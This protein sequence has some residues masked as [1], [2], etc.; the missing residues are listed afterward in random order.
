[1]IE[2]SHLQKVVDGRTVLDIATLTVPAGQIAALVGPVG[3]GQEALLALLTGEARPSLGQVRIAGIDPHLERERFSHAVGV[4]FAEDGLYERQS[5][6]ENLVFHCQL[7]SLPRAR[8]ESVLAQVGLGDHAHLRVDKLASGMKRRLAFGRAILH[9]PAVLLLEEPFARCDQASI[10]LL[11]DLMRQQ[12]AAGCSLLILATDAANLAP[13]CNTIY[14]L[15]QGRVVESRQPQAEQTHADLPF[16]VPVRLE[17]KVAL[18]N[19]G[20]ILFAEVEDGRTFLQTREG[21]LPTQFTLS[22]LEERL[23]RSGFFRAHRAYLVNMQHIKE[24]IP[25]TRDSFSLRLDDPA[26]TEIPL[27]KSAANELKELLG[28]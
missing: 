28:Y 5:A 23:G 3:S 27:S 21:R 26:N 1:M 6:L 4:L 20:D 2:L 9:T 17:G 11:S 18:V 8:A 25:Y 19:P 7:H 16:K 15:E 12:A 22:E 10:T 13:L 14:L 24:V